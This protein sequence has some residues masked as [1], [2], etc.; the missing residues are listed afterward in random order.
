MTN[1]KPFQNPTFFFP[2]MNK[3]ALGTSAIN[4]QSYP[5]EGTLILKVISP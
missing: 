2:F 1:L 5:S 4:S 3:N